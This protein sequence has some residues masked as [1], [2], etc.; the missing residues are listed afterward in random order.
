MGKTPIF[1]YIGKIFS[2]EGGLVGNFKQY[3]LK[4]S[5]SD[6]DSKTKYSRQF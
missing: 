5:S 6:T 1:Q 2:T 4:F 3:V